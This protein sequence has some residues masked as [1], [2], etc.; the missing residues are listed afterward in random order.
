MKK[1]DGN[2][3]KYLSRTGR[4]IYHMA[5]IDYLQ[6]F[7]IDKK[8]ENKLKVFINEKGAEISAIEPTGYCKRFQRFMRDKVIID[9]KGKEENDKAIFQRF[10]TKKF[11]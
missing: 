8:L 9:Q 11:D 1:F 6:D 10:K 3:H 7:N 5:I 4:F 2:R